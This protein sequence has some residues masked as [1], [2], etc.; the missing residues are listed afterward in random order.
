MC[1]RSL[2]EEIMFSAGHLLD[3]EEPKL[4]YTLTGS[5]IILTA[6]LPLFTYLPY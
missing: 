6:P 3:L 4:R 2:E 5:Y 1:V